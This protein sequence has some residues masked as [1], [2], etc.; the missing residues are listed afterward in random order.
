MKQKRRNS[1]LNVLLNSLI[2]VFFLL[3]IL[4]LLY[5]Y[6]S[7]LFIGAAQRETF[8]SYDSRTLL[9]TDEEKEALIAAALR[10]N[11]R[12]SEAPVGY[13]FDDAVTEE[14]MSLLDLGDNGLMGT[15]EIPCIKLKLPVY[16][17]VNEEILQIGVGHVQGSSLPVEGCDSN[18]ML[19]AHRGLPNSEL[20]N[21]IDRLEAGDS[22]QIK[23]L[24]TVLD[25]RVIEIKTVKPNDV[26]KIGITKGKQLCTLVTCTPYGINSDRLV[27]TGEL[28]GSYHI[29]MS[30]GES[31]K[32]SYSMPFERKG[33]PTIDE[34]LALIGLLMIISAIT[35]LL[36]SMVKWRKRLE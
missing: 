24:D 15:L 26:A 22:F 36:Y 3:C 33:G 23:V 18:V 10:Y 14:Y 34:I 16:H 1:K 11:K 19:M 7:N 31:V 17:T 30:G 8:Y 32:Y 35:L 2:A 29:D 4:L 20:F 27:V 5:P 25:Y 9:M 12:L 28:S 6:V 21:N 13:D